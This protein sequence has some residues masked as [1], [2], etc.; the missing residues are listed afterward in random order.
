MEMRYEY[1]W[2]H[3]VSIV[4]KQSNS[5]IPE[6]VPRYSVTFKI[7]LKQRKCGSLSLC[8]LIRCIGVLFF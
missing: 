5:D 4:L 7:K 6:H 1:D 3:Y 2:V 8:T